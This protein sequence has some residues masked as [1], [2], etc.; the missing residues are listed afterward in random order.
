MA[1]S[2][3]VVSTVSTHRSDVIGDIYYLSSLES[4]RFATVRECQ[5]TKMLA[6]DTGKTA[7]VARIKPPVVG[8]DF[9]L[10]HDLQNVVLVARHEGVSIFPVS[11]FPCFVFI[12]IP[13]N[14]FELMSP[15]R[16]DDLTIIGWGELYR[17]RPDAENHIF[18]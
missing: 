18:G 2:R 8:Q 13:N 5:F 4:A 7:V 1:R 14:E 10:S 3:F 16:S 6:F 17:T 11:E 9:N 15:I 12:A